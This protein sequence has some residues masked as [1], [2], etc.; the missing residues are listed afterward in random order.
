MDHYVDYNAARQEAFE[1]GGIEGRMTRKSLG[2][3]EYEKRSQGGAPR[4]ISVDVYACAVKTLLRDWPERHERQRHWF[5]A[6]EAAELVHEKG[7]RKL[8]LKLA[9]R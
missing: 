4:R 7:L 2:R 8:I 3:Y 9:R 6:Q 1:E 5:P